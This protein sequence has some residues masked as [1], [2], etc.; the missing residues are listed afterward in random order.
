MADLVRRRGK[1]GFRLTTA[2]RLEDCRENVELLRRLWIG[3]ELVS[4]DDLGPGEPSDYE[5]GAWHVSCHL[6]A[7]GGV[8]AERGGGLTWLEI[9]YDNKLDEYYASCAADDGGTVRTVPLTS[10]AAQ[11]RLDGGRVLG[12]V[13]GMSVGRILARGVN[14]PPARFNHNPRQEYDRP[15]STGEGGK[16]WEHWCTLRDLR[17][18]EPVAT[19]VLNAYVTLCAHLGDT[20]PA[21]VARG[22]RAY[23]HPVQLAAMTEAGFIGAEAASHVKRPSLVP[24]SAERLFGESLPEDALEGAKQLDWSNPPRYYMYSRSIRQWDQA[25]S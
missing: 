10:V 18:S 3:R 12:F 25:A 5:F 14:D 11:K 9:S 4:G 17:K 16:V 22:R 6:V 1:L 15:D 2:G 21:V 19:S 13:E 8:V 23:G 7:A 24:A 20:F